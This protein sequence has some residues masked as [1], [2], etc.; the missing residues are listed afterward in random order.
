[1]RSLST[2]FTLLRRLSVFGHI[3]C[4]A[5]RTIGH[6]I[7]FACLM[8]PRLHFFMPLCT[9]L[10]TTR[11]RCRCPLTFPAREVHQSLSCTGVSLLSGIFQRHTTPGS[12]ACPP[13]ALLICLSDTLTSRFSFDEYALFIFKGEQGT[14]Y[15]FV[16]V[17]MI[18][19]L[20]SF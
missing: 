1:M 4:L 14:F 6:N 12:S 18:C 2:P 16:C 17:V 13:T 3:S 11:A 8:L 9:N 15:A 5:A 7:S 19:H 10:L 20:L